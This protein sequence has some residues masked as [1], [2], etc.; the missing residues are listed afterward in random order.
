VGD[1]YVD[2]DWSQVRNHRVREWTL[3]VDARTRRRTEGPMNHQLAGR[4]LTLVGPPGTGKSTAAALCCREAVK[5]GRTVQFS[6]VPNLADALAG[7]P[8]ERAQLVKHQIAVDLLVWDDFGVRDLA[9]WE[10]GFLDQI[11]EG[12]YR[13]YA[14]M[15][16]TSNLTPTTLYGDPRIQR[17][18]DRWRDRTAAGQVILGGASM[19]NGGRAWA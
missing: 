13:R 11:V 16:V 5:A 18:A 7:R 10:I 6:Y 15:I 2:G 1:A 12:R 17:L 3:A 4:G 8:P 19:R 9:D 14:P